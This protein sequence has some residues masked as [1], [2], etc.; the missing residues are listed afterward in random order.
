[1]KIIKNILKTK[2]GKIALSAMQTL[3]IATG[4]AV[5]GVG[6]YF[7]MGSSQDVNPNTVFSSSDGA[8]VVYVAGHSASGGYAG[9][10]A[11]EEEGGVIPSGLRVELSHSLR[12]MNN[13]ELN[14]SESG[15]LDQ[16]EKEI[17]SYKMDGS[18]SGLGVGSGQQGANELAIGANG[19][20][21]AIQAQ[22]TALQD[23]FQAQQKA[24]EAQAVAAGAQQAGDAIA[25]AQAALGQGP[26][27]WGMAGG[28]ASASGNNLGAQGLQPGSYQASAAASGASGN[29]VK[30]GQTTITSS[31]AAASKA[32]PLFDGN[33]DWRATAGAGSMDVKSLTAMTKQSAAIATKGGHATDVFMAGEGKAGGVSFAGGMVTTGGASSSDFTGDGQ[34]G[35]LS[36]LVSD[37]QSEATEYEEARKKL[38]KSVNKFAGY[39]MY[40]SIQSV[41]G[42]I[43]GIQAYRTMQREVNKFKKEWGV[44]S[45]NGVAGARYDQYWYWKKAQHVVNC[46]YGSIG[47]GPLVGVGLAWAIT[48]AQAW[49]KDDISIDDLEGPAYDI[50]DPY[51]EKVN[52]SIGWLELNDK[53]K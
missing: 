47:A 22:I 51:G 52:N 18:S 26:G 27:K 8:D 53:E 16:R 31:L 6:A 48:S 36:G 19:D 30:E 17:S 24:A 44:K 23:K 10:G 39:C 43:N 14:K 21:S 49:G 41:V 35:A 45:Y 32:Q 3:G 50:K 42:Y 13:E 25:A 5:A 9:V 40:L 11:P 15:E 2:A 28:M 7:A 37:L 38:Q 12:M 20:M 4:V 29:K 1:M 34:I 46:V 33:V